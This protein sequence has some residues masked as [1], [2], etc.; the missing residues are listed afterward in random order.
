MQDGLS[1][2]NQIKNFLRTTDI[3]S[4]LVAFVV[5]YPEEKCSLLWNTFPTRHC[6]I[7]LSRAYKY[8]ITKSRPGMDVEQ[9]A[10]GYKEACKMFIQGLD[11]LSMSLVISHKK[12]TVLSPLRYI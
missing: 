1:K 7:N 8:M 5:N 9:K 10:E 11:F 12:A 2:W 3:L 6:S 4:Y